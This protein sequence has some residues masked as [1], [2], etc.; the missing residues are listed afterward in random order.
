V[1][2][3]H[4]GQ[5]DDIRVIDDPEARRYELRRGSEVVG[6]AAYGVD[7]DQ[8]TF[9]H[10]VVPPQDSGQGYGSRLIAGALHDVRRR[11]LRVVP[12]CPFVAAY[13]REHPQEQDLLA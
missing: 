13:V 4:A 2:V 11:G 1:T 10:T 9:T 5:V 12:R 8:V 7:G 3:G 6:T